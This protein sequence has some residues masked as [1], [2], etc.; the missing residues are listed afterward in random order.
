MEWKTLESTIFFPFSLLGRLTHTKG[1]RVQ[2][3]TMEFWAISKVKFLD[4]TLDENYSVVCKNILFCF[5]LK[6]LSFKFGFGQ[7]SCWNVLV[8]YMTFRTLI[9][10]FNSFLESSI[11]L[12]LCGKIS[13]FFISWIESYKTLNRGCS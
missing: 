10:M 11:C 7:N 13:Y 8:D 6:V 12:I 5:K 3:H 1:T 2:A 9:L 4:W